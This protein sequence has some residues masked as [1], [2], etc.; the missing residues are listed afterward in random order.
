[1][2]W[3]ED[4][5]AMPDGLITVGWLEAGRLY[6]RGPV[7]P[8]FLES[9]T[10]LLIDPWQPV[11]AAGN[12]RCDLCRFDGSVGSVRYK[13]LTVPVGASNLIVPGNGLLYVA[14]SLILHYINSHE[15]A[16]PDEFVEA[17]Q[18]CPPMRSMAYRRAILKNAPRGWVASLRTGPQCPDE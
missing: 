16:P 15:Y 8:S 18:S 4:L 7:T 11:T 1:M 12:H 6:R 3:F 2:A 13:D 10:R 17:V 14:P 9:L 5:A